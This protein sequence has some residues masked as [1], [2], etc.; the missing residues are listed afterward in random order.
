MVYNINMENVKL[1]DKI[2]RNIDFVRRHLVENIY[3]LAILE[4]VAATYADTE[5]IVEGG[6]VRDM[7]TSDVQKIINLRRAWEF[8]LDENVITEKT[9]FNIICEINKIIGRDFYYNAGK[10]RNVP[11]NITGTSYKPPEPIESIIREELFDLLNEDNAMAK[12]DR[13]VKLMIYLTKRQ[14]FIDGNKRT[15]VISAN[16]I[17]VSSGMGIIAVPAELTEEYKRLLVNYYEGS[18]DTQIVKF[19]KDHCVMRI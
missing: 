8:I 1:T 7:T 19:I 15:A 10:V 4:G 6:R 12:E 16:H 3:N 9:D 14:I 17:F 13:A 5:A 18:D 11:V 2:K